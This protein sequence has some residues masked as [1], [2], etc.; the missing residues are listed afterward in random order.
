MEKALDQDEGRAGQ[1]S[2]VP[3]QRPAF[4]KHQREVRSADDSHYPG[5]DELLSI[6]SPLGR[7][8]GLTRIGIHHEELPPGR[9]TSWP[10][11]E[12]DEEEFAYVIEGRP[13]VWIDGHLFPLEPGDAVGFPAGTGIAHTFINNTE[14]V[15]RLLVVGEANKRWN[16]IVYPLHPARNAEVGEYAWHDVPRRELGPHD[17]MPDALRRRRAG[18]E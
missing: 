6:G 16:R 13:D 1:L 10:H 7:A 4:I 18:T 5:S 14:E 11:A 15:V 8:V 17:G 2:V 3:G 12:S 9:R